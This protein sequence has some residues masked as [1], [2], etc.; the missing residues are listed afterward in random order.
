MDDVQAGAPV[1]GEAGCVHQRVLVRG[2]E[3]PHERDNDQE[4]R[5]PRSMTENNRP[6][7]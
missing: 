5:R 4:K 3:G 7:D 1:E 2:R 6:S